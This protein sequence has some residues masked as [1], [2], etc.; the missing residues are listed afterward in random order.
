MKVCIKVKIGVICVI[1]FCLMILNSCENQGDVKPTGYISDTHHGNIYSN[2]IIPTPMPNQTELSET[3]DYSTIWRSSVSCAGIHINDTLEEVEMIYGKDYEAKQELDYRIKYDFGLIINFEPNINDK[4]YHA[5]SI[6]ILN[7][8][9]TDLQA[10]FGVKIG[11]N[12][13]QSAEYLKNKY[14][15]YKYQSISD[16]IYT[17][18][19]GVGL[20]ILI[21]YDNTTSGVKLYTKQSVDENTKIGAVSIISPEQILR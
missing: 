9:L 21:P 2:S 20:C 11:D 13:M 5:I 8:D 6:M 10:K 18:E 1:Y 4:R 3:E 14:G 19:N 12:A 16:G 7:N 15:I 17:L